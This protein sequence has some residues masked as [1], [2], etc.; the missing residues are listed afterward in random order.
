[1]AS[2]TSF[3][4]PGAFIVIDAASTDGGAEVA[5]VTSAGSSTSIPIAG[6]PLLFT[7]ATGASVQTATLA[8]LGPMT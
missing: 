8:P 2:G 5:T 3:S 1:V 4:T 6:T 7:H